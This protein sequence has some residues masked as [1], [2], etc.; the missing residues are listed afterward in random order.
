MK[1]ALDPPFQ[2]G[3]ER[4]RRVFVETRTSLSEIAG[5]CAHLRQP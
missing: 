3:N 4:A 5:A 1:E 2:P